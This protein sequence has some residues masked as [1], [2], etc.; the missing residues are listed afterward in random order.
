MISAA[1]RIR[2]HRRAESCV[3]RLH[4]AGWPKR[5]RRDKIPAA[6]SAKAR[7]KG[8]AS[9]GRDAMRVRF[10]LVSVLLAASLGSPGARAQ[11]SDDVVKIGVLNDQ[12]GLYADLGGPGSVIAA[13]MAAEDFGGQVLGKPI[14]IDAADHQN[15]AD[16][17]VAIARRWFES[18]GVD[19]AIGFDHSAVALAVEQ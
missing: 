14:E 11:V 5:T 9:K 4:R 10:A 15:K 1:G 18:E 8:R 2:R 3:L 16:V 7:I 19:L 13:R 17:G 6:R 12:T